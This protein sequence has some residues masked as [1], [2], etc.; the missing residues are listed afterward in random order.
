MLPRSERRCPNSQ[1]LLGRTP[2]RLAVGHKPHDS[3]LPALGARDGWRARCGAQ[4]DGDDALRVYEP[5]KKCDKPDAAPLVLYWLP[6]LPHDVPTGNL[7][8]L[9]GGFGD[10]FVVCVS[11]QCSRRRRGHSAAAERRAGAAAA[12]AM[13]RHRPVLMSLQW[14]H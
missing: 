3:R 8:G 6:K 4:G 1:Y 12:A 14:S 5:A 13:Q 9:A 10:L 11:A 2:L 7:P